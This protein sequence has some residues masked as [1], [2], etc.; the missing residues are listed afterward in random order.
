MVGEGG[1]VRILVGCVIDWA[2]GCRGAGEDE[3]IALVLARRCY[4][5]RASMM[6]FFQYLCVLFRRRRRIGEGLI[7]RLRGELRMTREGL[8]AA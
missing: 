5:E 6:A 8:G 4:E 3:R 7:R 2:R 1:G